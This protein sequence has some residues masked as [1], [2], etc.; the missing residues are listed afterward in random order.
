MSGST[1]KRLCM[2]P[3]ITS[4]V[5]NGQSLRSFENCYYLSEIWLS[6]ALSTIPAYTFANCYSLNYLKFHDVAYRIEPFAFS[7]AGI[8]FYDFTAVTSVPNLL[9]V[10]AFQGITTAKIVVPDSLYSQ[11]ISAAQWSALSNNIVKESDL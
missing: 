4:L 11:W 3:T 5:A 2:P 10:N 9:N 8:Q 1:I 7:N 6:P